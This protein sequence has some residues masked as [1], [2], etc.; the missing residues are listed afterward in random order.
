MT[1][2]FKVEIDELIGLQGFFPFRKAR[3]SLFLRF[4]FFQR[5][6]G[7]GVCSPRPDQSAFDFRRE[8][9]VGRP[10]WVG[11]RRVVVGNQMFKVKKKQ[12]NSTRGSQVVSHLGTDQAQGCLTLV[13]GWEPVHSAWYGR[14]L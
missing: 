3:D 8:P 12:A 2:Y 13:F 10:L 14:W 6:V 11:E 5:L 1:K 7:D 4:G 9:M